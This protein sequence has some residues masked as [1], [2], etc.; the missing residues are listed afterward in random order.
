MR[1]RTW[2]NSPALD[3]IV[4]CGAWSLPLLLL[5]YPFAGGGLPAWTSAFYALSL[6]FNYPHYMATVYR[7]YH[8]KGDFHRYRIYTKTITAILLLALIAAHWSYRLVPLLF[9]LYVTWSPWHYMGQNFGLLMMFVRRNGVAVDAKDRNALRT[10]F[11]ASYLMIFLSFHTNPSSDPYVLSLGLPTLIDVFRLP[12]LSIFLVLGIYPLARLLRKAGWRAMLAPIVLYTTEFLWFVLPTVVELISN[13]RVPQTRYS[14][15]ILAV[16]HSAQYI[17]IT[18]YFARQEAQAGRKTAWK[19]AAYFALLAVGGIA[20]FVPVPWIASWAF[21]RDFTVSFFAV[22]ALVNIHHFILDGAV[23]KLHE[24][25]VASVLIPETEKRGGLPVEA[26]NWPAWVSVRRMKWAV[27]GVLVMLAGLDQTRYFLSVP[28]RSRSSLALAAALTPHDAPLQSR[29]G[30][31]FVLA[32]DFTGAE[33]AFQ[34]AVRVNPEYPLGHLY[35]GSLVQMQGDNGNARL[36]YAECES[37][38]RDSGQADVEK[39][40]STLRIREPQQ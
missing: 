32:G 30:R 9:T 8:T 19:P 37:A 5:A 14:A 13:V 25:R 27:A 23:W 21:G 6:V 31:A 20:L 16:M 26:W 34:N 4:G 38:A 22:T 11:V 36:Q 3:L 17:W 40:C 1:E 15:G 39:I 10:A 7:A 24:P 29:L 35:L 28:G 2:I 33:H 12:L 18:S